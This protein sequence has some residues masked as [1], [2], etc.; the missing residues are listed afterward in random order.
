MPDA[1]D[2]P[3]DDGLLDEL[4][5]LLHEFLTAPTFTA[6]QR[7]VEHNARLLL[8]NEADSALAGLHLTYA[9]D[10]TLLAALSH[11]QRLLR[12]CRE[13]GVREA[14]LELRRQLGEGPAASDPAD[15][16]EAEAAALVDTIGEFITAG[17]WEVS[18]RWLEAHPELLTA[19]A[20]AVFER[21][22]HTH[23]ARHE[24]NVV[25]ELVIHRDLLR[26][27]REIGVEAAFERTQNPPATLDVIAE[28]TIAVLTG[29]PGVRA[30]WQETVRLAR[31]RAAELDDGPMLALLR[32]VDRLVAGEPPESIAPALGGE[33][34]ACWARIV[35]AVGG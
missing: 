6:K 31:I 15:I 27:C 12:R 16:D 29:Q 24:M 7:L 20:D 30:G 35:G 28:N 17:D 34:A 18:R 5:H 21:L 33:H 11:H 14:F 22:I 23:Q 2:T 3:L 4:A 19:S 32:A 25:R 13:I 10:E 9:D 26:A 8:G 1:P